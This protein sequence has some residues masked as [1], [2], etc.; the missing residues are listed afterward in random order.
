MA[1]HLTGQGI[2][3]IGGSPDVARTFIDKQLDVWSKVV[4]ENNIKAD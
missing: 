1:A 4:R 2:S 3:V